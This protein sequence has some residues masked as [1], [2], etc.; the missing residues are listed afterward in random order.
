VL[1]AKVDRLA[2]RLYVL[3]L[4]IARPVCFA[5]QGTSA[6]WRSRA[7]YGHLNF[8]G[9]RR[10]AGGESVDGL[11]LIDHVDHVCDNCLAGKQR[12]L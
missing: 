2:N 12:R 3:E 9:L 7:R 10:L 1:L 11:P 5:M 8:H 6:A 4:N